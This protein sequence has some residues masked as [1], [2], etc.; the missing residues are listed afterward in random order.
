MDS[1]SQQERKKNP[2]WNLTVEFVYYYMFYYQLLL[3]A[4][5]G[6]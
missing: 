3:A 2:V 4:R 1:Y 6:Y 5:K